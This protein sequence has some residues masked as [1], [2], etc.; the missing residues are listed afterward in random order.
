[1]KIAIIDSGINPEHPH[2]GGITSSVCIAGADTVDHLGHGTAVA[3]AIREKSSDAELFAVKVFDRRL[4]AN[5]A[6]IIRALEWSRAQRVDIINL[7]LGTRNPA[8]Q[9]LFEAALA[10]TD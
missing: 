7:S 3:G 4:S 5:I 1:M 8:H 2:V 6:T 10:K 9:P